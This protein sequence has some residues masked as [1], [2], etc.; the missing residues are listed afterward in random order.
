MD[1]LQASFKTEFDADKHLRKEMDKHY[2]ELFPEIN[3]FLYRLC[4]A[5]PIRSCRLGSI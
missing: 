1:E 4:I 3:A 5:S 2:R